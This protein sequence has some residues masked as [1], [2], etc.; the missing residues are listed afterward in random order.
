MSS[1]EVRDET[2]KQTIAWSR[3]AMSMLSC[4]LWLP[5]SLR[6]NS[7]AVGN[8]RGGKGGGVVPGPARQWSTRICMSWAARSK[9]GDQCSDMVAGSQG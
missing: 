7:M 8:V 1:V 9:C 5:F 4:G 3:S 2:E 6:T